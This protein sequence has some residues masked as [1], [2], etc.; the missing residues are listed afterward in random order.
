ML[1]INDLN[2]K[3]ELINNNK[4]SISQ[5]SDAFKISFS[6]G[7]Y[8][9][10]TSLNPRFNS[11]SIFDEDENL[12][13]GEFVFD[14]GIKLTGED[15]LILQKHYLAWEADCLN[16]NSVCFKLPRNRDDRMGGVTPSN[17]YFF[18][19]INKV[20]RV[21]RGFDLIGFGQ[22]ISKEEM[23]FVH[24][25][26]S[27]HPVLRRFILSKSNFESLDRVIIPCAV[28]ELFVENALAHVEGYRDK[29]RFQSLYLTRGVLL[30]GDPDGLD[31]SESKYLME[32]EHVLDA[33]S[34]YKENFDFGT[35]ESSG[36]L[37]DVLN[38]PF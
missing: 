20:A 37:L 34:I 8:V 1:E 38:L 32:C 3:I 4:L 23:A 29:L 5:V 14:N 15:S 22:Y 9:L 27:F 2:Q 21:L 12:L 18:A 35:L 31:I 30:N 33:P 28:F 16:R 26:C 17:P 19:A 25:Y 13:N 11:S 6:A 24:Q 10:L 36:G 7:E